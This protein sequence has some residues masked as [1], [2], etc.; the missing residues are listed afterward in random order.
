MW[1][2]YQAHINLKIWGSE[3][4]RI[5]TS[6]H[7]PKDMRMW[8]CKYTSKHAWTSGYE[9]VRMQAHMNLKIWGCG[10]ARLQ[11]STHEPEDMRM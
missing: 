2:Y 6:A 11:T 9:D 8:G 10:D 7:E 1:A 4:A 5:P 3:D